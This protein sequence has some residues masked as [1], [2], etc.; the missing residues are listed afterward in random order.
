MTETGGVKFRPERLAGE[1]PTCADLAELNFYRSKLRHLGFIGQDANGIGFGNVSLKPEDQTGFFITISGGALRESI[2]QAD[3]VFV[4]NWSFTENT[5]RFQG[6]GIPSA[7]T[8]THAAIYQADSS[9]GAILHIHSRSIWDGLIARGH[10]TGDAAEYG[11]TAM[12]Q[13]V[14]EFLNRPERL[15]NVFAMSGH[16]EGVL[17]VGR[18][19]AEAYSNLSSFQ[20]G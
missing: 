3:L 11:T 17:A 7:E 15:T 13:G 16:E 4:K 10:A 12:A 19:L 18:D 1:S 5:V 2:G 8:L 6:P 20:P 14:R 9:A